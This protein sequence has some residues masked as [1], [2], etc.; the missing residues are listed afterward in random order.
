MGF[1]KSEAKSKRNR[2]LRRVT[3]GKAQVYG[4]RV[5]GAPGVDFGAEACG[6]E[7]CGVKG[8][9]PGRGFGGADLVTT[10]TGAGLGAGATA[11]AFGLAATGWGW[12]AFSA[13]SNRCQLSRATSGQTPL[14]V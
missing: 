4:T 8:L 11:A 3:T 1:P 13:A 2:C 5:S 14:A 6:A 7:A 9:A 10:G 12:Q